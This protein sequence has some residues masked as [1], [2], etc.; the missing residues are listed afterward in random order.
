MEHIILYGSNYGSTRRYA[1]KLSE[2]PE[3]PRSVTKTQRL[4]RTKRLSSIW[5]LF[6]PVVS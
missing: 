2:K 4:F 1:E 6:M 3:F 5:G